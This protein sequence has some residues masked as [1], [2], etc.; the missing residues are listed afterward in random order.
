[1]LAAEQ[2]VHD[3]RGFVADSYP[4]MD[5][6]AEPWEHDPS[7]LAIYFVEKAFEKLYPYQRWHYLTHLIPGSYQDSHLQNTIWF[8]LAPGERPQDLQFPDESLIDSIAPDVLRCVN[9]SGFIEA[10]DD[11]MCPKDEAVPRAG[12]AGDFALSKPLLLRCGFT[13]DEI[14]DV[15]HVLMRRGG[16][17]DCEI[18]FNV[19][20]TSRLKAEYWTARAEGLD[21]PD[22]HSGNGTG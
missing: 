17:C 18:L 14:Y 22:P 12:C 20:E 1:M 7:R 16:F 6:S 13:E 4:D 10:L 15:L 8:E 5:V 9:A 2:I 3:L 21:V 11:Q 19:A